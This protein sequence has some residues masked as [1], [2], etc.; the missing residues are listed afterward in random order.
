[1]ENRSQS[2]Q[3]IKRMVKRCRAEFE[4]PEN[5]DYYEDYREAERKYVKFC[6]FQ[7]TR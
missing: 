4:L 3:G 5:T 1:M 2:N 7:M 6:L